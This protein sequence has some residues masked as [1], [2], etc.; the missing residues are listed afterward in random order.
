M[1]RLREKLEENP[2]KPTR[3]ITV[4]SV[5]YK[6][7]VHGIGQV[8]CRIGG[9]SRILAWNPFLSD[10]SAHPRHSCP[11]SLSFTRADRR[12]SPYIARP[13]LTPLIGIAIYAVLLAQSPIT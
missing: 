12:L 6:L 11:G 5:G 9:L 10:E 13:D 2:N 1:R 7:V 3:L 4:R 8:G